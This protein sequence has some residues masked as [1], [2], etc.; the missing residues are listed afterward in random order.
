MARRR[1][2][3]ERR[4]SRRQVD[5]LIASGARLRED[6]TAALDDVVLQ[7]RVYELP[8]DRFMLVFGEMSGLSGKGD[9]YAADVFR[10]FMRWSAKVDEDA[11]RGRQSS[12]SHWAYYSQ[13]G[14]RLTSFDDGADVRRSRFLLREPRPRVRICRGH[15]HRTCAA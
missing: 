1:T 4:L 13:L 2:L 6:L 10:R 11:K 9:I 15:R 7:S 3:N 12:V 14:D 5:E 8:G